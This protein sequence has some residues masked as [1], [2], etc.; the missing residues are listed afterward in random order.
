M[1]KKA[2]TLASRITQSV[3]AI[4]QLEIANRQLRKAGF[5]S[6]RADSS[7]LVKEDKLSEAE[8]DIAV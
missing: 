2:T 7:G 8:L 6:D 4:R 3:T 5:V 1:G